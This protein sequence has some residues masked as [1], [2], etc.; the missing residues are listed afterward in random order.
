MRDNIFRPVDFWKSAMTTLP[1]G[2]FFDLLRSIF[3]N[4]KTPYNKQKLIND[5]AIFLTR[6]EIQKT[7]SGYIDES[8]A[9]VIAAIAALREPAP[10]ELESFFAGELSYADLH[11][12][13]LNLEERFI[14]YRFKEEGTSRI[15]LNPA[16]AQVLA[17]FIA[18]S[19]LLFPSAVAAA[20]EATALASA[21]APAGSASPV[22]AVLNGR[23]LA[24]LL[25]FVAEEDLFFK[26]EG[27]IRKKIL[28]NAAV[29]F[30]GV[31]FE[32]L[33]GGL[34]VL[35]LFRI[36][37]DALIPDYQHFTDFSFL[38]VQDRMEYCAAGI[39]CFRNDKGVFSP[40]ASHLARNRVRS[41]AEFL[42]RFLEF[43]G[44]EKLFPAKT[45][46][47]YGSI[48]ELSDLMIRGQI[49]F[50][51][52]FDSCVKTGL[53]TAHGDNYQRPSAPDTSVTPDD[54]APAL[55]MD[56]PFSCILYPEIAF[57]DALALA[58]FFS[59][60]E[61]GAAVRFE[62][63]RES[64]VRGFDRG[65][66]AET[67]IDMLNR[68]SN[69]RL[70]ETLVWTLQDW[71]KR[72]G[73][74]SLRKGVVLRLSEERRY[75]AGAEPVAGLIRETLAPGVYLLSISDTHAAAEALEKAGVDIIANPGTIGDGEKFAIGSEWFGLN[76]HVP[77]D[78]R[79]TY[80][81]PLETAPVFP[82]PQPD[83]PA[84]KPENSKAFSA[85]VLKDRFRSVLGKMRLSKEERDELS[86]RIERRLVLN[87]TQLEGASVRYEKLEARGLDYVGKAAIAKQAI[88]SKSLVEVLWNQGGK[89]PN[90]VFGIPAAL[91]KSE[92]ES[93]LVLNPLPGE[94]VDGEEANGETIRV[95][96]GKISLLRRIKKSIFGE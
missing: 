8:D 52:L 58:A 49:N 51:I 38:S 7:I 37:G 89:T 48:L 67:M 35:G 5:L 86:A 41:V 85:D 30:S 75:L 57:A 24:G 72:Y 2:A 19:S 81:P 25:S 62:L 29:V 43:I 68:L 69:N 91:E 87:E 93:I 61:A 82:P 1:D 73:E 20:G 36:E 70:S 42:H 26:A 71:E 40:A 33:I 65:I 10:G 3:G 45:L 14:I 88:A 54:T 74:I 9:R 28:E 13:L 50:D 83:L 92:G 47:R 12:I 84:A 44:Q 46:R 79:H 23:V 17:P 27:V 55:A 64:V 53:L 6:E 15:A 32:N 95:P 59:L 77:S 78:L 80:F 22:P 16:L 34:H 90:R 18:D 96:L 94:S 66:T 76:L 31:D 21:L 11:D 56:T 4:V 39:Y 63:T 60:R